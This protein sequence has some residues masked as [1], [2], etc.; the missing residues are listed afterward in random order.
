MARKP[1]VAARTSLY[2][3]LGVADLATGVQKKYL[4]DSNYTVTETD[5]SGRTALLVQ[6]LMRTPSVSWAGT[7]HALTGEAI[8]LGNETAA[9]VLFIRD[10]DEQAWALTYGMGFQLLDQTR[11]DGG[12]GQRIAIRT[13]DPRD[14][15]S[16]TRTTLDHRSRTDRFSIPGGDHLRG[17]GVG[18]Y[19]EIVSRLVAKAELKALTGGAKPIRIRGADALSVPLGKKPEQLVKDLDVL[20]KILDTDPP[21]DLAVLEQL[22]AVRNNPEL[23]EALEEDLEE[24]LTDPKKASRLSL[25][26]PHE[27]IEENSPATSFKIRG[28][29][30]SASR[31]VYDGDP[32]LSDLLAPLAKAGKGKRLE[33]LK[34]VRVMLYRDADATEP[35]SAAIPGL[36]WLAFETDRDGKR[37]CLHDGRWYLMDQDY[38]EKLR[39]RT[40][41][42]LDRKPSFNL[43]DW[44]LGDAESVYNHHLADELGG[45][46][47]D[48]KLIRTVLHRRGI[49]ACDVLTSDGVLIHVKDLKASAPASHLLA[50]ALVST[51]AL[52]HDEEARTK[53]RELVKAEGGNPTSVS[54]KVR[55]VV[56][57]LGHHGKPL[58][59]DSLFT[60]TQVTLARQVAALEAQG[61]EVLVGPIRRT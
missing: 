3:L 57:G 15:N 43:P 49:E 46:F 20:S 19:G 60:F 2:R 6:G 41:A 58:S 40:Q 31:K 42:I 33:S 52:L 53:L 7:L 8:Q 10:D 18:D 9:A 47:L 37:Y 27:R 16:L 54:D 35:I 11:V 56:L 5:V 51:D 22:V 36:H 32:T 24:A 38:A 59:A 17:F 50:Q 48:A 12:F 14:L 4:G 61:V 25:S 34:A 44:P 29:G 13:A 39:A 23:I 30:H 28:A 21:A 26:W 55:T 1:S 45:T